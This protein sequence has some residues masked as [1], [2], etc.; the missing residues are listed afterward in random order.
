MRGLQFPETLFKS[1]LPPLSNLALLQIGVKQPIAYRCATEYEDGADRLVL[2][3]KGNTLVFL[4]HLAARHEDAVDRVVFR[5]RAL[6]NMNRNR[7]SE[8]P[9]H[10]AVDVLPIQENQR[11]VAVRYDRKLW[12]P[13]V[14]K[15]AYPSA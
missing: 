8:I 9:K 7:E 6:R 12:I 10:G 13:S 15:A 2:R 11:L 3:G 4:V 1:E 5:C 14:K